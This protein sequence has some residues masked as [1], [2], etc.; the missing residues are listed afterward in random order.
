MMTAR[1]A[2]RHGRPQRLAHTVIALGAGGW[3]AHSFI[4]GFGSEM[5]RS[6]L[7][8]RAFFGGPPKGSDA[9]L[10]SAP[11]PD[12]THFCKGSAMYPPWP[13]G[14]EEAMFGMGCFWCSENLF[15]KMDG[16]FSTQV[17][18]AGGG[19]PNPSYQDICTGQSGHAEVVRV[20]YDPSVVS[21]ADLLKIF[22]EKHNPTTPN[23]QGN[24]VGTQYR[25]GIYYYSEEQRKIAEQ[26]KEAYQRAVDASGRAMRPIATE[27]EPAPQ[28]YYAEDY[29]QQYD[30]KPGSRYYCGLS[31]LGVAF[32]EDSF[33]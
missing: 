2:L 30:A 29:H 23:Q 17:G 7:T 5:G 22:W 24:D 26:T 4:G 1:R 32:P 11:K 13:A 16:I 20:V 9:P 33:A 15:M 31:P 3:F 18:Y 14:M 21:Y 28:F 12:A 8:A 19:I 27:I 6:I 10:P 25:S